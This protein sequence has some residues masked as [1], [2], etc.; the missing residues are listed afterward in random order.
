LRRSNKTTDNIDTIK[1]GKKE[2]ACEA[3]DGEK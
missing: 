3:V 2:E 1:M